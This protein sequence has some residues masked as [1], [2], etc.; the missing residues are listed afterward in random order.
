MWD[1]RS[2]ALSSS[3]LCALLL[4]MEVEHD[5]ISALQAS[6]SLSACG[7]HRRRKSAALR[8]G[9]DIARKQGAAVDRG[10]DSKPK[11]VADVPRPRVRAFQLR[12]SCSGV[13]AALAFLRA[14]A[15]LNPP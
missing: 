13:L 6:S 8:G 5:S 9:R 2:L 12:A 11:N 14:F 7:S 4:E 1:F 3:L 15:K 10:V